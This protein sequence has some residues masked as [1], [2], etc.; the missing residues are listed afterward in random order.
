MESTPPVPELLQ[1]VTERIPLAM[2]YPE[3][4]L[5]AIEYGG[6][7]YGEAKAI[8][9]STQMTHGLYIGGEILGRI[10]IA[11]TEKYDFL[12]EES[13]LLGGIATRLG[14]YIENRRL[15]EQAQAR[16]RSEEIL[17]QVT[18]RIRGSVNVDTI[19]RT[20][21]QEVGQVLGRPA[22]VYLGNGD[23]GEQ[24]QMSKEEKEL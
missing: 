6:E 2:Q 9:L 20:A 24:P 22:F 15:F 4:C 18:D 8:N 12:N 16:A 19:M 11:Y 5:V 23:N 1:W 21:A 3:L 7:V 14:G 10:Y 17:R 13:A